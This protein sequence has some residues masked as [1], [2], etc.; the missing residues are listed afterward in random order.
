MDTT[1]DHGM[2]GSLA[3]GGKLDHTPPGERHDGMV[4]DMEERHLLVLFT[5]NKED[6]VTRGGQRPGL[7]RNQI[8]LTED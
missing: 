8:I 6:L 7:M 1:V 2:E 5:E 4:I 3:A